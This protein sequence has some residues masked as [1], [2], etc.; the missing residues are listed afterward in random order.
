[1]MPPP[2]TTESTSASAA[3]ASAGMIAK[4]HGLLLAQRMAR[5]GRARHRAPAAATTQN[6]TTPM[7]SEPLSALRPRPLPIRGGAHGTAPPPP[8][9]PPT[10]PPAAAE[11]PSPP[12]PSPLRMRC[13]ARPPAATAPPAAVAA[14][15]GAADMAAPD[16]DISSRRDRSRSL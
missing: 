3:H 6:A 9:P 1:M 4:R 2:V 7:A 10:P 16:T 15:H 14:V 13:S 5:V 8:P 12:R 11:P